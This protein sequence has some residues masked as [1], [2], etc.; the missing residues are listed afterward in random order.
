MKKMDIHER[1]LSKVIDAGIDQ[2]GG[3]E[4]TLSNPEE[5]SNK[6]RAKAVDNARERAELLAKAAG[7]KLGKPISISEES[8]AP[9]MPPRPMMM[10]SMRMEAAGV[11]DASAAPSLPGMVSMRESVSI[12]YEIE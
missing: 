7:V 6:L 9:I 5:F 10:K 2:V 1:L 12:T 8:S 11:G 4:F 3:V